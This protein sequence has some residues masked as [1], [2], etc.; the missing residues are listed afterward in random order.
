MKSLLKAGAI[1]Q[2][3]EVSNT[4]KGSL[5]SLSTLPCTACDLA[6]KTL[7]S[8]PRTPS[9]PPKRPWQLVVADN[10]GPFAVQYGGNTHI[11]L[12]V[13]ASKDVGFIFERNSLTG[14]GSADYLATIDNLARK[15]SNGIENF[16]TDE[17]SDWKSS[18]VA[19]VVR[20]RGI[21]HRLA[22]VDAHGQIGKVESRFRL[23]GECADAMLRAA[24]APIKFK[25]M[26]IKFINYVQNNVLR[27]E[28]SRLFDLLGVQSAVTFYP[29]W[30]RVTSVAPRRK[31]G[32]G[33]R[34]ELPF[35]GLFLSP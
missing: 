5:L 32:A 10:C 3:S 14:E 11:T 12:F 7:R 33:H 35:G 34:Q 1:S 26:A 27:G 22:L 21:H 2:L 29:F 13:E 8:L 4:L 31:Q 20:D 15:T 9:T 16:R 6:K 18:A 28:T 24:G 17:G 25:F 19:E 23:Y 30:C